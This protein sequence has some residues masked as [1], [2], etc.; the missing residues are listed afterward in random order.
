MEPIV[1]EPQSVSLIKIKCKPYF[2][3]Q[4]DHVV[5]FLPQPSVLP[6]VS[7]AKQISANVFEIKVPGVN[8][9]EESYIL[10]GELLVEN[11]GDIEMNDLNLDPENCIAPI[12]PYIVEHNVYAELSGS[13]PIF[14]PPDIRVTDR[15]EL[16]ADRE[17]L[18]EF[19]RVVRETPPTHPLYGLIP[20]IADL[21][22]HTTE[23]TLTHVH[24]ITLAPSPGQH[25]V[26][27]ER[28][29][30]VYRKIDALECNIE[31]KHLLKKHVGCLSAHPYDTGQAHQKVKFRFDPN[32]KKITAIY[33]CSNS[34]KL[35]FLREQLD[36]FIYNG[37]LKKSASRHGIP[38]FVTKSGGKYR[39]VYDCRLHNESIEP[40]RTF[41]KTCEEIVHD[42]ASTSRF[43]S[44][45]D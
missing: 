19:V 32:Y 9:R 34:E 16:E 44:T 35:K 1:L 31:I 40:S 26:K 13:A 30:I 7:N 14:Q 36:I 29:E 42:I 3:L 21:L 37:W 10:D 12:E 15:Q 43:V 38:A 45:F 22:T 27:E 2:P 41:Y 5:T 17:I 18:S 6:C 39:L 11:Y 4:H 33:K 8:K 28:E 20:S 25:P 24:N 23:N